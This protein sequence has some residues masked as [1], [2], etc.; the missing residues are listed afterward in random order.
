MIGATGA[1]TFTEAVRMTAEVVSFVERESCS[2]GERDVQKQFRTR[3]MQSVVDE[4]TYYQTLLLVRGSERN[5]DSV[6]R[7]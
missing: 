1:K 4:E 6:E 5:R 7:G 3:L 2:L